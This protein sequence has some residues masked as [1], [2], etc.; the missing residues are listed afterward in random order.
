VHVTC[1]IHRIF[2]DL[3]TLIILGEGCKSLIYELWR[4]FSILLLFSLDLNVF[5]FWNNFTLWSSLNVE[6][7]FSFVTPLLLPFSLYIQI[8][9]AMSLFI[10][11]R[12]LLL[13]FHAE[14]PELTAEKLFFFRWSAC[15]VCRRVPGLV[16]QV[17]WGQSSKQLSPS[18]V[19]K[20]DLVHR[21]TWDLLWGNLQSVMYIVS[22]VYCLRAK[23]H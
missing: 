11:H 14:I 6:V 4:F 16:T 18:L 1:A 10:R 2:C 9:Y 7:Q 8:Y 23:W 19:D 3:N 21:F 5:L 15:I 17:A 13:N 12:P 22:P 20:Q